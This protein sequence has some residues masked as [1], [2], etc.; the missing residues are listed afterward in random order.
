MLGADQ[1]H[2]GTILNDEQAETHLREAWE[3]ESSKDEMNIVLQGLEQYF[4]RG[5]EAG[6]IGCYDF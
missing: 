3:H 6:W 5:T 1:V 4:W 2:Q